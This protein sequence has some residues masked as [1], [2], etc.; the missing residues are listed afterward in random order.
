[1]GACE[2]GEGAAGAD[3]GVEQASGGHAFAEIEAIGHDARDAQVFGERAHDVVEAL[4]YQDDLAA[5]GDRFFQLGD[6]FFLQTRLEK[7]FEE[8]LAEEIE[9]VAADSAEDCVEEASGE[10][11]VGEVE[12][13]AG[14]GES[15]HG[16][17]ACPTLEEALRIPGE[18]A[19]GTD[20][21]EV[22]QAA[23]HAPEDG[24]AR[25]CRG[26]LRRPG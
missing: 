25:G 3:Y 5:G 6:A 20:S 17:A 22:E 8:L 13:G 18:E 1:L 24:F 10:D 4:A 12:E 16:A 15:G 21:G 11:A 14:E 23:F 2:S 19:D 7:I 26:L 9:A